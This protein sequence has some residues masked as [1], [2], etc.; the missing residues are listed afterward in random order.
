MFGDQQ[1][2]SP[3]GTSI[4]DFSAKTN[5]GHTVKNITGATLQRGSV[6]MPAYGDTLHDIDLTHDYEADGIYSA[7]ILPA[8]QWS[9]TLGW[10]KGFGPF[11][12]TTNRSDKPVLD[13]AF[14]RVFNGGATGA[15]LEVLIS[16]DWGTV[17]EEGT[18]LVA[19]AGVAHLV[20]GGLI[21]ADMAT[22]SRPIARVMKRIP[23][24][25]LDTI[26]SVQRVPVFFRGL[27]GV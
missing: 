18:L 8:V 13:D 11:A 2:V 9:V 27:Y 20:V 16:H 12:V 4:L 6:L 5:F 3:F 15:V 14:T 10:Q 1:G 25:T 19:D 21:D 22:H 26:V 17:L 24:D 23:L 7:G